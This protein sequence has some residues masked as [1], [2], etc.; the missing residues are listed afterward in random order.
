MPEASW[1]ASLRHPL[2]AGLQI[3]LKF[4]ACFVLCS[5]TAL[6]VIVWIITLGVVFR[7]Q[8]QRDR[9]SSNSL[10]WVSYMVFQISPF[11]SIL[12]YH[13]VI[14]YFTESLYYYFLSESFKL[15]SLLTWVPVL[16]SYF[17]VRKSHVCES[18]LYF[19]K[20]MVSTSLLMTQAE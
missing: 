4:R 12:V 3:F 7:C 2:C 19:R 6:L 8:S 13:P 14:Y 11:I 20:N 1:S 15:K 10:H 18:T 5:G 16:I 9:K 17:S